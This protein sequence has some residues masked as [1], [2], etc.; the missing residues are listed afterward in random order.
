M[1]K[2]HNV[3]TSDL[4]NELGKPVSVSYVSSYIPRKCG[5]ATYTKDL[6]NALNLINPMRLAKIYAMTD[7][8]S[9]FLSYPKE[10]EQ[11][12]EEEKD[13]SYLELA[14]KL[15]Q[16]ETVD[17]VCLQHEFGIFGGENGK[18][19]LLLSKY[20]KKPLITTLHTVMKDEKPQRKKII[21]KL[22]EDSK[23]V[24]VML[25]KTKD[26]LIK[27]FNID[28]AKIVPIPHGVPD[29]PI[30]NV[31]YYK[32]KLGLDDKILMTSIN[33]LSVWK[34]VEYAI[35]ALPPVV[36][37]YPNFLYL[38]IG[39]THPATIRAMGGDK[40]RKRLISLV[41]RLK[42]EDNV[43]FINEYI[44]LGKLIEYIGAS[45]FYITPYLQPQQASSGALSY[46]IGAGKACIST[47]FSYAKEMLSDNAGLL[48]PFKNSRAISKAL[49][50]LISHH[51]QKS[52][53]EEAAYGKGRK[54]TWVRVAHQY[55][56]LL[57][58]AGDKK[59]S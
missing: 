40:Y 47:E 33:L 57:K 52:K 10:V 2:D 38:V 21:Q 39:E 26:I 1:N 25:D 27:Y 55:Y 34:G 18:K 23:Y 43:G 9:R 44:S 58:F 30:P 28:S 7:Q 15:N 53:I 6:T 35:S 5:I 56:H 31:S 45:D 16:D 24:V 19:V 41:K 36:K 4:I 49:L 46:A 32:Q 3:E 13:A 48:V 11:I 51:K 12:V 17:V 14:K 37:K 20:L 59:L 29:F 50:K 42:L 22:A 8:D 54:M